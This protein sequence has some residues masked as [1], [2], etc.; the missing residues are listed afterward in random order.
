MGAA[1]PGSVFG[2]AFAKELGNRMH[3]GL[4]IDGQ[5]T[6]F[7]ISQ[8]TFES[9]S[10]PASDLGWTTGGYVYGPGYQGVLAG[11][12]HVLWTADD[13]YVTPDD[14][15]QLV[16]GLVGRGSGDS[17]DAY[18]PGCTTTAQRQAQLDAA[19]SRGGGNY[20]FI[21]AYTLN[22]GQESVSG[23]GAF[24]ITAPEPASW[25]LLLP[26]AGLL[27]RRKR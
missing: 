19:A 24:D 25:L 18:C 6:Q 8:L 17:F 26:L 1:D 23:S 11:A 14:P 15:T 13:V 4:V 21:G 10:N 9:H 16:D 27:I 5:G 20:S 22:L 7:S 12:D 3:F 2:A